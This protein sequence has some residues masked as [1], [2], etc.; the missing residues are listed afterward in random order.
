MDKE[1]IEKVRKFVETECNKP[2]SNYNDAYEH[3]FKIV[4]DYALDLAEKKNADL[5]IVEI[6]AWLHDMGAIIYGRED[7]HITGMKIAEEKLTEFIYDPIKIEKVKH[8]IFV[9][10]GSQKINTR[11][12]EAKILIEADVLSA[13]GDI[14][15]LFRVA[16]YY[17]KLSRTDG[18]NSVL[19]KLQ[20]K[21]DQLQF[22]ESKELIRPKMEAIRLLFK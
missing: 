3:H 5:E 19:K 14:A 16:Y 8:C 9:H 12:L 2:E 11:S 7:H 4:V 20:N 21:W 13:F 10:R 17:E 15:G 1:I 22:E 18:R 6:A